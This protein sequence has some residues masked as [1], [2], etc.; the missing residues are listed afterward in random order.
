MHKRNI[1]K[2]F[3]RNGYGKENVDILSILLCSVGKT[4]VRPGIA[5]QVDEFLFGHFHWYMTITYVVASKKTH[6]FYVSVDLFVPVE[7]EYDSI[8]ESLINFGIKRGRSPF[9]PKTLPV[10]FFVSKI[11]FDF[12]ETAKRFKIFIKNA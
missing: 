2:Q 9:Q 6:F 4:R 7:L 10:M 8:H 3:T 1:K 12:I 5:H 11:T